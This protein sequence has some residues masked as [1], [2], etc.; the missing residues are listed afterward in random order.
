MVHKLEG[1]NFGGF[2]WPKR[3]FLIKKDEDIEQRFCTRT[4]SRLLVILGG[5]EGETDPLETGLAL[6]LLNS[7]LVWAWLALAGQ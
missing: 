1:N 7:I 4:W 5:C 3:T 6:Q 2:V